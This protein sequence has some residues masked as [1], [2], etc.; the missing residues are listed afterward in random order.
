MKSYFAFLIF[1]S[2]F[3]CDLGSSKKDQKANEEKVKNHIG[4]SSSS[5]NK[6]QDLNLSDLVLAEEDVMGNSI[7]SI[8]AIPDIDSLSADSIEFYICSQ[9][10][11]PLGCSPVEGAL[12]YVAHLS[13]DQ[14][15][16]YPFS[17]EGQNKLFAR[18]CEGGSG[19]SHCGKWAQKEFVQPK[20]TNLEA[21]K[22]LELQYKVNKATGNYGRYTLEL[23][24]E[25]IGREVAE[26]E[27]IEAL[28]QKII[29]QEES[30]FGL[31]LDD[32]Q[33][34]V[35]AMGSL[36]VFVGI[37][38]GSLAALKNVRE[39]AALEKGRASGRVAPEM[40]ETK[41]YVDSEQKK[42]GF[43]NEIFVE[44]DKK[45]PASLTKKKFT[46]KEKKD[47]LMKKRIK[48][49]VRRE[50]RLNKVKAAEKVKNDAY[51]EF[52]DDM[53]NSEKAI[54]SRKKTSFYQTQVGRLNK[55]DVKISEFDKKYGF[56]GKNNFKSVNSQ[57]KVITRL[58][59]TNELASLKHFVLEHGEK[60]KELAELSYEIDL[61]LIDQ[62]LDYLEGLA[63]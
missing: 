52:T 4:S 63:P 55:I 44:V 28:L 37:F 20:Y 41:A 16:R 7:L 2:L 10:E 30:S 6:V 8:Q 13:L 43:K 39:K 54:F 26:N 34:A 19:S 48:L 23:I 21:K 33:I 38:A 42:M 50:K 29:E 14:A 25:K 61:Y 35:I 57:T 9:H 45:V 46:I 24:E 3:S 53:K 51:N 5:A 59:L 62:E 36:L 15:F 1:L 40:F 56:D 12:E 17:P 22:Y 58:S 49:L 27:D 32:E 47:I 18:L 11:D 60:I 31:T